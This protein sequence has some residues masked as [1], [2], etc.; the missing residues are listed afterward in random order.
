MKGS[1]KMT[2][3]QVLAGMAATALCGVAQEA[4]IKVAEGSKGR[5]ARSEATPGPVRVDVSRYGIM[6]NQQKAEYKKER[7]P[8]L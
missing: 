6:K 5:A 8:Y 2:R 1:S 3:R 7:E 4:V